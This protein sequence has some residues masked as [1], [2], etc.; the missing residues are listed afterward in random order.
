MNAISCSGPAA[1]ARPL[2][3]IGY[4]KTASTWL[5]E[6]FFPYVANAGLVPKSRVVETFMEV[7]ALSFDPD[8]ARRRLSAAVPGRMIVSFENLSGYPHNG[9]GMGAMSKDLAYRL[10]AALPDADIVVFIRRQP[11][12]LAASYAQ[13]VRQGGTHS[14]DRYLFPRD[15]K[16]HRH[17]RPDKNPRFELAHFAY[18]P[19]LQLYRR[20]FGR[21][22]VHVY[23]YEAFSA[24]RAGFVRELC[25]ELDLDCPAVP[26]S[27]KPRNVSPP[28][29][30]LQVVRRI[31]LFTAG[32]VLDKSHLV[33]VPGAYW[34]G[35]GA[36]RA[37]AELLG[38]APRRGLAG[39]LRDRRI[40]QVGEYYAATNRRLATEFALPLERYGYP[41]GGAGDTE[42]GGAS[43]D[44]ADRELL[45]VD[46]ELLG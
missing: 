23:L 35:R 27:R 42:P 43:L 26:A 41:L 7:G 16:S 38:N 17:T 31:N 46:R 29:S 22:R 40:N 12:I 24:D 33:H 20:L 34:L 8:R 9:G 14:A 11:D 37:L 1:S 15:Y 3:H 4:P 13:Y 5:Q 25:R 45:G 39:L 28:A 44:R 36:G 10:R 2:V 19:L 18:L 32:R 6:A 21:D 30:V